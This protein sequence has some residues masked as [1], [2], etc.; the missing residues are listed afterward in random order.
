MESTRTAANDGSKDRE[1]GVFYPTGHAL[2][3]FADAETADRAREALLEAVTGS[4]D[5]VRISAAQVATEAAQ[6]I[7]KPGL[8]AGFGASLGIRE[9]QLRL[10]KEGAEFVL[11]KAVDEAAGDRVLQALGDIPLRYG[12][13]YG[14]LVIENL[15][16]KA[17]H[18]ADDAKPSR[19]S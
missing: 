6:E 12:V 18:T 13:R 7:E 14:R 2:L 19:A 17:P 16:D 3:G 9:Q 4:E 10:A 5:C 15:V 8:L 1:G 11:V